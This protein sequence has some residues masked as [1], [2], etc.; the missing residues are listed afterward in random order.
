MAV[1]L[2]RGG[3]WIEI[4]L[5]VFVTQDVVVALLRGGAWIEIWIRFASYCCRVNVALLR[6]GAWIEIYGTN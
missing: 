3:A 5:V 2:L 1:A 4:L 6:G